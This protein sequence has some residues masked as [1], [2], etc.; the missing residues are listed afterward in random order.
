MGIHN[1][2]LIKQFSDIYH[3]LHIAGYYRGD[4][5]SVGAVKSAINIAKNFIE[6]ISKNID[7]KRRKNEIF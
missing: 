4:L 6:M 3:E 7:K 1:G 2:K 5:R